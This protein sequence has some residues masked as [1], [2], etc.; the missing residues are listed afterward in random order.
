MGTR[1]SIKIIGDKEVILYK[2]YDG[3]PNYLGEDLKNVLSVL[4]FITNNSEYFAKYIIF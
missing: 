2:H 1:A 3:N 4:N